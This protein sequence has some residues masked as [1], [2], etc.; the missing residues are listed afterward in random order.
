[1]NMHPTSS[2]R[3]RRLLALGAFSALAIAVLAGCSG[4]AAEH[5]APPAQTLARDFEDALWAVAGAPRNGR[6]SA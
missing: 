4:Q 1:M 5:G 2:P 3:S 6:A